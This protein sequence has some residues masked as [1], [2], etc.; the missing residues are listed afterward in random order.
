LN[1][2]EAKSN[3]LS[4]ELSDC[5]QSEGSFTTSGIENC[6]VVQRYN[7]IEIFRAVSNFP[8]KTNK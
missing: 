1:G 7:G 8:S 4:R 2:P 6:Y 5:Y 3:K